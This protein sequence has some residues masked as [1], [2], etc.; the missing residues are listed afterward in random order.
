M[1][2]ASYHPRY[3]RSTVSPSGSAGKQ[4]KTCSGTGQNVQRKAGLTA[5]GRDGEDAMLFAEIASR[6]CHDRAFRD[7]KLTTGFE[8]KTHVFFA[9]KIE[10]L[11]RRS[12]RRVARGPLTAVAGS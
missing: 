9:H 8:G 2:E 4:V 12:V 11:R 7:E 6:G 5:P 1:A 3:G 10:R